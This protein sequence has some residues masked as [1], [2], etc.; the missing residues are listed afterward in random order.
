M[1]YRI[2]LALA[3]LCCT[4]ALTLGAD[5]AATAASETT[6]QSTLTQA[7][8]TPKATPLPEN[9]PEQVPQVTPLPDDEPEEVLEVTPLPD[10]MEQGAN[11]EELALM[12]AAAEKYLRNINLEQSFQSIYDALLQRLPGDAG[13]AV[14][15]SMRQKVDMDKIKSMVKQTLK[16]HYTLEELQALAEFYSSDVGR[17]ISMKLPGYLEDVN[18]AIQKEAERA[19]TAA[20]NDIQQQAMEKMQAQQEAQEAAQKA[21]ED[22]AQKQAQEQ[23]DQ[24]SEPAQKPEAAP[25]MEKEAAPEAPQETQ[26]QEQ[27]SQKWLRKGQDSE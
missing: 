7:A 24:Q 13:A 9:Q 11:P 25:A 5:Q 1:P 3:L 27:K 19:F 17:S 22:E 18:L 16:A 8:E 23:G 6:S 20:V 26:T 15:A 4:P 21:A 14:I 2:L 10:S 12:D